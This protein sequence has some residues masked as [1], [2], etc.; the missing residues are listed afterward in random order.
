[1]GWTCGKRRRLEECTQK[2]GG[3]TSACNRWQGAIMMTVKEV[4]MTQDHGGVVARC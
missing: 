1:M 2:F 3:E 4:A